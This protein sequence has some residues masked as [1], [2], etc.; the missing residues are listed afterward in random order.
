MTKG[1]IKNL[2]HLPY[3]G[4]SCVHDPMMIAQLD[5]KFDIGGWLTD[6]NI[7]HEFLDCYMQWIKQSTLNKIHNLDL[8]PVKAYSLGTSESFDKFY[9]KNH[10]RRFRALRGEYMY[11]MASWR[12]FA[13]EWCYVDEDAL[14][15]NDALVV[16]VP[17]SDTG[18][19]PNGIDAI[20]DQCDALDIPVLIDMSFFGICNGI[21]FDLGR[22]CI[23]DVTFSLSKTFPVSHARIGMRLTTVD[24]D[25]SL[26]VHH[27]TSYVNRIGCGLG[28]HFM[29]RFSP[30]Y[31]YKTWGGLQQQ[32]CAELGIEPSPTVIFGLDKDHFKEYNRGGETNRLCF[33]KH[34]QHG[35]LPLDK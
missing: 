25:D 31:N 17:F 6:D 4:A 9:L 32:F 3:G 16:S 2:K 10:N 33:S 26:L 15:K 19:V 14:H 23:T 18:A 28:M 30:D 8:F 27:K 20:L 22:K 24:D 13:R 12:N 7:H 11:H 29:E 21:E 1:V 5:T 35:R 34:F